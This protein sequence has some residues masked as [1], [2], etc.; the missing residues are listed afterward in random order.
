MTERR[1][2]AVHDVANPKPFEM[3]SLEI[4]KAFGGDFWCVG[5]PVAVTAPTLWELKSNIREMNASHE[6]EMDR[7]DHEIAALKAYR[8]EYIVY[9]WNHGPRPLLNTLKE[10]VR[11]DG[12]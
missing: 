9:I 4:I 2:V 12:K 3:K 7:I 8:E 10:N 11:N 1:F 5:V 6:K